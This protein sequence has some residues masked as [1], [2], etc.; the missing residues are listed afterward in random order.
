MP[1]HEES[2]EESEEDATDYHMGGYHP[3][4]KGD[5]YKEGRYEIVRKLGWGHFSTVWL[6]MDHHR[7]QYVALKIVKSAP[8]YTEAAEDEVKLLEAVQQA[9]QGS[10]QCPVVLLLDHFR[11]QGIH[12]SHVCMVMEVLGDNLLRLIR[13]TDHR[14]MSLRL[15]RTIAKQVLEGLDLLHRS[16]QIIHTDLKPENVL[17][18]LDADQIKKM[19]NGE[20][21]RSR[22]ATPLQ[23]LH[24]G[25][26][27]VT[28]HSGHE[29]PRTPLPLV[30]DLR[31]KIADLGN[32]CW[33]DKHFT[34]DIQTR[35]YR[36]PEVIIGATYDCS[37]DIWSLACMLF[38]L[39]TGD[40]LFGPHAGK[41]Y[42]KD[43]DHLAQI[44][45]LIGK[46]PKGFIM[47][48]KNS[49]ALFNRRGDLRHI[50]EMDYWHLEDVLVEKYRF[51]L[52]R[53]RSFSS[54]LLTMLDWVPRR[55]A[56]A[57]TLLQHAWLQEKD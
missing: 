16:C 13:R 27:S 33:V 44:I 30:D 31:V 54:F 40:F 51:P 28:L 12:G 6:A 9:A 39:A 29:R 35:Q 41:R 8:H 53:A 25:M 49:N 37:A 21:S 14:G 57:A 15:V 20:R 32:A 10:S 50:Q 2:S 45:E 19:A 5:R 34:S 46:P 42:S 56:T 26:E 22:C 3:V 18:V 36:S 4:F 1:P 48:G 38:E 55:R 24:S 52:E 43:E 17:L 47:S 23:E 11:H 7:H